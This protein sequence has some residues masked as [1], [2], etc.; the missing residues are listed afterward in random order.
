MK[1]GIIAIWAFFIVLLVGCGSSGTSAGDLT[2]SEPPEATITIGT[3]TYETIL[4]TYCW[5]N[6]NKGICVDTAGPEDLLE[7]KDPIPVKP[8]EEITFVMGYEPKPN[9]ISVMQFSENGET[10]V[11]VKDNR[12]T[13]PTEKGIYYYSYGVWWMDEDQE[14]VSNGDAFYAFAIEVQ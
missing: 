5:K 14:N 1:N 11:D 10:E 6:G 2:G 7:G 3:E 13:A 4:G 9:Q 8:G 12:F